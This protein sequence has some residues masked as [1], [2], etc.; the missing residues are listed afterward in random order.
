MLKLQ[1]KP[2]VQSKIKDFWGQTLNCRNEVI[3]RCI[4]AVKCSEVLKRSGKTE[5]SLACLISSRA[6]GCGQCSRRVSCYHPVHLC[7]SFDVTQSKDAL[8]EVVVDMDVEDGVNGAGLCARTIPFADVLRKPQPVRPSVASARSLQSD[9]SN[10]SSK[11]THVQHC[12]GT[13][14]VFFLCLHSPV[15]DVFLY[16]CIC[17][18]WDGFFF[19]VVARGSC[20]LGLQSTPRSPNLGL[21]LLFL[22]CFFPI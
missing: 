2:D 18:S 3:F 14:I 6:R 1:P 7:S 19:L 5:V 15:L 10:L 8:A 9:S 13:C 20:E 21:K 16:N 4:S 12:T 22:V 17:I 11:E